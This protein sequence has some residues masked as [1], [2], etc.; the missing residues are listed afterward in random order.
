MVIGRWPAVRGT[1]KRG[2]IERPFDYVENSLLNGRTFRSLE[3]LN[4]VTRWWLANVADV[5]PL[6]P[7]P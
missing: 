3:H 1:R 6:P 2:K 4:E 5:L 7:D